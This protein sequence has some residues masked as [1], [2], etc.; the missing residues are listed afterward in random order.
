MGPRFKTRLASSKA[1]T[2]ND[3]ASLDLFSSLYSLLDRG[4]EFSHLT[5]RCEPL[6]SVPGTQW[7]ALQVA[8][9]TINLPHDPLPWLSLLKK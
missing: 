1:H 3:F 5:L 8:T 2:Y 4:T 9:I 7:P 6:A